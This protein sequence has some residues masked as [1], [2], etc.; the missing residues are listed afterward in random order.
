MGHGNN[1][2]AY[3]RK[4]LKFVIKQHKK[5]NQYQII[6][7]EFAFHISQTIALIEF[8]KFRDFALCIICHS[9]SARSTVSDWQVLPADFLLVETS[10]D[11]GFILQPSW[12]LYVNLKP[13]AVPLRT[14]KWREME[15]GN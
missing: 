9:K 13:D 4:E 1:W 8:L 5:K 14:V 2:F 12:S 11:W 7:T 6:G 15:F 3:C 10:F